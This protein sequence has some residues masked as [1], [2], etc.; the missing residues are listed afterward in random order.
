MGPTG[1]IANIARER[2]HRSITREKSA[3]VIPKKIIAGSQPGKKEKALGAN[4]KTHTFQL[5]NTEKTRQ[6]DLRSIHVEIQSRR[7]AFNNT[8]AIAG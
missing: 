1:L 8:F 4:K 3:L 6:K 5:I 2:F 7:I